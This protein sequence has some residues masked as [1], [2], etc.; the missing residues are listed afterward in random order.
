MLAH[1]GTV[2]VLARL[3]WQPGLH[4]DDG[5]WRAFDMLS[6]RETYRRHAVCRTPIDRLLIARRG[7]PGSP[8]TA[9]GDCAP[10]QSDTAHAMLKLVPG[11]RR[12]SLA[13]GLRAMGCPDYLLL[14]SY[15][16]A[17][18]SWLDAWQCD[19]LLLTRRDWPARSTLSPERVVQAALA[20]TGACLDGA[21][22][23]LCVDVATVGKAARILL[24][25]PVDTTPLSMGARVTD[26]DIWLR[27]AALEKMLCMSST[28]Q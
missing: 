21:P 16:R 3:I 4:M 27:L 5:W 25:P 11:L 22:E 17:L 7:W 13:H 20:A 1:D 28:L 9:A 12:L 14:G 8:G 23:P 24:P 10:P 2:T 26:E 18:S 19:R 15:R 6:W